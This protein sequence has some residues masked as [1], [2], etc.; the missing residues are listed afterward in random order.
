MKWLLAGITNSYTL[1]DRAEDLVEGDHVRIKI[2]P[3]KGATP[4]P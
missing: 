1:Q 3:H 2:Y 4:K